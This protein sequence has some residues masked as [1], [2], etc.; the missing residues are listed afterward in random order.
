VALLEF[1]VELAQAVKVLSRIADAL[2]RLAPV[3]VIPD[4]TRHPLIGPSDVSYM[5]PLKA[6]ELSERREE[7]FEAAFSATR[8]GGSDSKHG[9]ESESLAAQKG[10]DAAAPVSSVTGLWDHEDDLDDVGHSN[11]AGPI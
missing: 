7:Q 9:A 3:P 11:Y 6:R 5:T 4:H 8:V 1:H 10:N 2:E